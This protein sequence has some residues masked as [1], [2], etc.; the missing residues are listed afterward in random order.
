MDFIYRKTILLN[1]C[2]ISWIFTDFVNS[3]KF[4]VKNEPVKALVAVP[5]PSYTDRCIVTDS[6]NV[7][8]LTILFLDTISCLTVF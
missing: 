8:T 2:V 1:C 3:K 7:V 4:N 5:L 6:G